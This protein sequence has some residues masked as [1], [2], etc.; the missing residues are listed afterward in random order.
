MLTQETNLEGHDIGVGWPFCHQWLQHL[1]HKLQTYLQ[2]D[3][4]WLDL[5]F[6]LKKKHW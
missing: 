3:S 4:V 2:R 1:G 5:M 6:W